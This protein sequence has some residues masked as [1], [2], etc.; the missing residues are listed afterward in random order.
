MMLLLHLLLSFVTL[1]L[2][3]EIKLMHRCVN[4]LWCKW[5]VFINN[6]NVQQ[7]V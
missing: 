3:L 1:L 7:K 6:V 4:I 5:T 2:M